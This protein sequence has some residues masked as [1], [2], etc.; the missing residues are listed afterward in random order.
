M[1]TATQSKRARAM[2]QECALI[3]KHPRPGLALEPRHTSNGCV[4]LRMD[5]CQ[6]AYEERCVLTK[7]V[8][9]IKSGL[10]GSHWLSDSSYTWNQSF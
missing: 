7:F 6:K 5:T 10:G 9:C 4:L 3:V 2:L 1:V 8:K